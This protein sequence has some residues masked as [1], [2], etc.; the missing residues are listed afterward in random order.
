MICKLLKFSSFLLFLFKSVCQDV[1][2]KRYLTSAIKDY[3]IRYSDDKIINKMKTKYEIGEKKYD[4]SNF[5]YNKNISE[6]FDKEIGNLGIEI[7]Q[8]RTLQS[9]ITEDC[10]N[11]YSD[12]SVYTKFLSKFNGKQN[13]KNYKIAELF[14][15]LLIIELD[16]VQKIKTTFTKYYNKNKATA[17]KISASDIKFF[18]KFNAVKFYKGRAEILEEIITK[19]LDTI[20]FFIDN[21]S[22]DNNILDFI[23]SQTYNKIVNIDYLWIMY[24]YGIRPVGTF[25]N[26]DRGFNPFPNQIFIENY[27]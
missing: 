3:I 16:Y 17:D 27:S 9:F 4:F 20:E 1:L 21:S 8:N 22:D 6:Y 25:N 15:Q 5:D 10:I 11:I 26:E 23:I 7:P 13:D 18:K 12:N 24:T 14:L 2:N 19:L